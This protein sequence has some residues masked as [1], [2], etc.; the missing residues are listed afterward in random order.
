MRCGRKKIPVSYVVFEEEGHGFRNPKNIKTA[1]ESE[2]YF[3]SRI[4]G[5]EVAGSIDTVEIYNIDMG[6]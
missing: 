4:F 1:L 3:Y 2:L 5:F 6:S